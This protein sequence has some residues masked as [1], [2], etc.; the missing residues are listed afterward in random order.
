[1]P[2]FTAHAFYLLLAVSITAFDC[3]FWLPFSK[4]KS[5]H[6]KILSK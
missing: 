2:L 6:G 1:M 3:R 5:T 4:P